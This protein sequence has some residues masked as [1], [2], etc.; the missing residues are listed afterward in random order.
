MANDTVS[1]SWFAVFNN[2]ADHGYEGSPEEVCNKL[3]DEWVKDSQT[4][5]GAWAY[6]ISAEGLHH[7]HMVLED[8]KPM[9]F[10]VV[11]KEYAIGMHFEATKGT[12]KQADD[13]INKRGAFEEKGET[14]EYIVYHG[15]IKG[16]QGRRGAFDTYYD[17]LEAGETPQDILSDT[18][19]AYCHIDVI[20]RMYYDL[21]SQTTPIV[22]PLKVYW[23]IG[24]SGSGKSYE[25]VKLCAKYGEDNIF[26]LTAFNSGSFD[27]YN[28]QPVLWIEDFRGEFKLQELLRMLDI[29]KAEIPARYCNVK[30]LW[31]EVHITSVLT[32]QQCY[33]I[34]TLDDYDRIEQLLRRITSI[35]YHFKDKYGSYHQT[36]FDSNMLLNDM[37][38][39]VHKQL[40]FFNTYIPILDYSDIDDIETGESAEGE[41]PLG[42]TSAQEQTDETK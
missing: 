39:E 26:Y 14:V 13:Y 31:D 34:A 15:D 4:R 12:K 6:C 24:R 30:A 18:P 16:R 40:D 25:R 35:V 7:I 1:T 33:K 38:K 28:G 27:A 42:A 29:Y 3:R 2:P 21:R 8:K 22:R 23:H 36:Y 9:R 32:P 20:K 10:S 17:R 11:K 41:S 5:V 19:K 37:E